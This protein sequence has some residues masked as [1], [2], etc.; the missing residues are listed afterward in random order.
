MTW[1]THINNITSLNCRR[2]VGTGVD[3]HASITSVS[4]YKDLTPKELGHRIAIAREQ[5]NL[6]QREVEKLIGVTG[7][8]Q[9]EKGR[10]FPELENL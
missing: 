8:G 1:S 4:A 9:W 5:K 6:S 3:W 7:I 10:N 2:V